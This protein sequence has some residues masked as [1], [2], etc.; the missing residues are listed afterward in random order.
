MCFVVPSFLEFWAYGSGPRACWD[1]LVAPLHLSLPVR[2]VII[3]VIGM[4]QAMCAK[5]GCLCGSK[6]VV[7]TPVFLGRKNGSLLSP[8]QSSGVHGVASLAGGMNA[9]QTC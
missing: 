2:H 6:Y 1:L 3:R 8:Q 5:R 4:L 9:T 7:Y